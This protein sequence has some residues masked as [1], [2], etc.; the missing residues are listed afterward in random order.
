MN[1][2]IILCP[3]C[4][5]EIPLTDA[6]T[7]RIREELDIEYA[8]RRR[9]LDK[10][11]SDREAK[12]AEQR[13]QLEKQQKQLDEEVAAKLAK[14]RQKLLAEAR[15]NAQQSLTVEMQDLQARLRERED[16]L[17]QA[18]QAELELRKKQR[19]LEARAQ[20]M[21]LE[22]ARKLDA[23]CVKV[24]EQAQRAAVEAERFKLAEKE[25]VISDLHREIQNLKQKAEQGSMQLQGEVLELDLEARLAAQFPRDDIEPVAKGQRGAD[26]LQRV[27]TNAGHYCGSIKWETK[28]AKNWSKDWPAKLKEDQRAAKADLAV[29]V[30][31]V[32]PAEV[33]G[34]GWFDGVWMCDATFAMPLAVALRQ[35]VVTAAVARQ[36]GEG[37]QSKMEELFA[38]LTS[39]EFRQRVEG[40]VETFKAMGEDLEAEKRA[41]QKHWARREKQLA[42]AVMHTAILYGSVQGIVG[43]AAL[44]EIKILQLEDSAI[45]QIE[46]PKS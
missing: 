22:V 5:T 23:E 45:G 14:E 46:N 43:Q 16:R 38:Y 32:L 6:V 33:N 21:E 39:L 10:E 18:Q 3:N 20:V 2:D 1:T 25:K 41:L 7:H 34:F 28:R 12:L 24:R 37:R 13:R 4:K 40:V 44:P 9:E 42:Q 11:T 36:N 30:S 29:L 31:Q 8:A 19:D 27:H 17:K 26:V 15:A 35:G